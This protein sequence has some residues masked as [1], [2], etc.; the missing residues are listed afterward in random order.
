M[1]TLF[2]N[3]YRLYRSIW[4]KTHFIDT[5]FP[6][7]CRG[8]S[9]WPAMIYNIPAILSRIVNYRVMPRT[10]CYCRVLLQYLTDTLKWTERRICDCIRN[11]VIRAS[12]ASFRPHEIVFTILLKHKGSFNITLWRNFFVHRTVSIR[13]E[14]RKIVFQL[15]DVTVFPTTV[16]H[17]VLSTIVTEYELINRLSAILET[18]D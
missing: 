1:N 3:F 2:G 17:I 14:S 13:N 11:R 4:R 15:N 10:R 6:V 12:P 8:F 9:I 5:G 18:R 7:I 16:Y